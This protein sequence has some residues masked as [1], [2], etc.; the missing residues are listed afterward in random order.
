MIGSDTCTA[1]G[2]TVPRYAPVLV[3]CRRLMAAGM[4]PDPRWTC[5]RGSTVATRIRSIGEAAKLTVKE[6]RHGTPVFRRTENRPGGVATAPP[7]RRKGR[8][9]PMT[10]QS[11]C[12]SNVIAFPPP[13]YIDA[14]G[15]DGGCWAVIETRSGQI[16]A[17]YFSFLRRR[18]PAS[19]TRAPFRGG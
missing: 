11:D 17:T 19:R 6:D 18:A 1:A 4:R 10:A 14:C 15:L 8:A 3:L 5:W 9:A 16:V 2:I 7:M 13:F 12:S